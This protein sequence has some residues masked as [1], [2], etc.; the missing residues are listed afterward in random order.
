MAMIR[1]TQ[2]Y[3]GADP[4]VFIKKRGG[5]FIGAFGIT[6]GTKEAPVPIGYGSYL[7]VDGMALEFNILP[8]PNSNIFTDRV[9]NTLKVIKENH[10]SPRNFEM[11]IQPTVEF[12][13]EEWQRV[14]EENKI[15][16][17]DPD[18]CAWTLGLNTPPNG[19]VSF[20]TGAGHIHLGWGNNF[21]IDDN[22]L[23]VC[24]SVA[25]E[26]D[27]T[28]GLASLLFDSDTKRRKLYGKAGAFRPKKYGIEYRT[29][30]N[31]WV[32]SRLLTSYVASLSFLAI[33]NLMYKTTFQTPEVQDIIND[34]NVEMAIRFMSCN[35][36]PLPPK[37]KRID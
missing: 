2:F 37:S 25:K 27:A 28:V 18:Y 36:I 12:D 22:F 23:S 30:S 5:K 16:G 13:E 1:G 21:H 34:G 31:Q 7:Q 35:S 4:E 33:S 14:P 10:L 9:S 32:T 19:D 20:R 3:I 15:L 26:M 29:L 24:A 6:H 17:C 11:V 8:A